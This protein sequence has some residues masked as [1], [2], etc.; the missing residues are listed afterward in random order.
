MKA[1]TRQR[2]FFATGDEIR[3][4]FLKLEH[5]QPLKYFRSG[6]HPKWRIP[7]YRS[8]GSIPELG[9]SPT[10]SRTGD[11]SYLVLPR[12]RPLKRS[13]F[14]PDGGRLTFAIYQAENPVSVVMSL[15]GQRPSSTLVAGEVS[16]M[17]GA[18]AAGR[19]FERVSAEL[20]R[21]FVHHGSFWV[22]P[23]AVSLHRQGWRL[24]TMDERQAPEYDLHLEP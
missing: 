22:S 3:E 13:W 1:G 20:F 19:L 16:T 11:P 18:G 5:A 4:R 12:L 14:I 23:E 9:V 2:L 24:A 8:V 6:N 10:G 15:G 17:F 21:G 7:K